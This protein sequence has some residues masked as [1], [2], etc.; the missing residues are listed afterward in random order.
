MRVKDLNSNP[1]LFQ[2]NILG[3]EGEFDS[4]YPSYFAGFRWHGGLTHSP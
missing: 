1:A 3:I 2:L 4:L